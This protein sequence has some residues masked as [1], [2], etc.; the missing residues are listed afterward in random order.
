MARRLFAVAVGLCLCGWGLRAAERATFILTDGER[1][2]GA[3][4][5]HTST[6]EN[7]IDNDF[8]ITGPS[9]QDQIFHYDQVAI[10]DFIGGTP[11]MSE[12][13]ALPDTGH[14]LALRNGDTKRGHFVNMI[15]GVTVK[16]QDEGAPTRDI[17]IRDVARIYLKPDSAR[18]TF[19][20]HGPTDRSNAQNAGAAQNRSAVQ[21][22]RGAR[23]SRTVGNGVT[24]QGNRAWT[25]SG[26]DV[27]RDDVLR[28]DARGEVTF[29]Q[30]PTPPAG[31]GGN[32]DMKSEKYPVPS[33]PI[34]ALIGKVGNNGAPFAIGADRGA[35]TMPATG[36]LMLGVNDD[37][38]GDNSGSF[39]VTIMR[40]R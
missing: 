38:F 23:N 19:N 11:G 31:P 33:Q 7:L 15:G 32:P 1:I 29:I 10:I 13:G 6:R 18:N 28:F 21:G 34:A 8:S 4:A 40:G 22:T 39:Q 5:F 25:D 16:W 14:L 24:V 37:G 26:I 17:P 36:R 12:L 9:G 30:G 3:V 20:Y 2:S 35:I 27:T